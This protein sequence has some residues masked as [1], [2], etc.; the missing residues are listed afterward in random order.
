M[1][2]IFYLTASLAMVAVLIICIWSMWLLFKWTRLVN[3]WIAAV[4]K[5]NDVVHDAM[6][7]K[8]AVKLKMSKFILKI[9]DKTGSS[10]KGVDKE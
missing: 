2:N 1:Q 4:P 5:W 9:L 3:S 6:Y 8:E 7:F 10:K